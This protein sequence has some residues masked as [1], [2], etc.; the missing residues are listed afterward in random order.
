M[1]CSM[2]R[3][4]LVVAKSSLAVVPS[5]RNFQNLLAFHSTEA[6]WITELRSLTQPIGFR[7]S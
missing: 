5:E 1:V 6:V 7:P 3:R 4:R 2:Y